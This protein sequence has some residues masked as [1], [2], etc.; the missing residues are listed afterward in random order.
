MF[1]FW[2]CVI[3]GRKIKLYWGLIMRIAGGA[4]ALFFGL[5]GMAAAHATVV[6]DINLSSQTMHVRGNGG[7]YDW[8]VSTARS[9]YVTPHGHYRPI[10]LQRMHYSRKYH[11][12][13]MP[14]S[15][16]FRGGYAIHGTYST[17]QLGR[18]VSHGCIRLAPGNAAQ[19]YHMVQAEGGSISIT[20][21]PPRGLYARS[22]AHAR[23]YA[24]FHHRSDGGLT[25]MARHDRPYGAFAYAPTRRAPV[26][27]KA[28]H[29]I[30]PVLRSPPA[31][32]W[33]Y[34]YQ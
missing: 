14:Y 10:A 6:I 19:L 23:A 12:S 9:G 29:I 25:Y 28:S 7:S 18:P 33:P 3:T 34:Y 26:A 31:S 8:R 24:H 16:F 17:A 13:P 22:H 11:M 4:C 15:I 2:F 5:F 21:S 20:G 1:E 32:G 27:A 30:N